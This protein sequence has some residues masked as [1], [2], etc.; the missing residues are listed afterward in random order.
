MIKRRWFGCCFTEI[1]VTT[2]ELAIPNFNISVA[3]GYLQRALVHTWSPTSRMSWHGNIFRITAAPYEFPGDSLTEKKF[4]IFFIFLLTLTSFWTNRHPCGVT[5]IITSL[6]RQNDV[7]TS[8]WRNNDVIIKPSVHWTTIHS[9]IVPMNYS[10]TNSN[11]PA[12]A[13]LSADDRMH[14]YQPTD[15]SKTCN[16]CNTYAWKD[17]G[18]F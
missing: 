10:R 16:N 1:V 17:M 4:A 2:C 12:D 14:R 15:Y 6:L 8:F 13:Q 9:R 3:R 18:H 7:A 5:V 11:A